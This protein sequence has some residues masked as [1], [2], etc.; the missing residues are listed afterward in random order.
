MMIGR[1]RRLTQPRRVRPDRSVFGRKLPQITGEGR[2]DEP[3]TDR[4]PRRGWRH[5]RL[6]GTASN[7]RATAATERREMAARHR[8]RIQLKASISGWNVGSRS[9]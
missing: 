6:E 9:V 3:E 4:G 2:M 5:D 8:R 7:Y 1:R